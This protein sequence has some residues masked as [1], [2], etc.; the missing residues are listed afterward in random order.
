MTLGEPFEYTFLEDDFDALHQGDQ[1]VGQLFFG[2]SILA[3]LIA[4]L[5][6][7]GL[8]SYATEQRTKEIG[9]RKTLG[10]SVTDIVLLMS[11]NFM[12]LV[13]LALVIAI[14]ITWAAMNEWLQLFA[15]RT[16]IDAGVFLMS[17]LMA[18]VIAFG[19]VSFQSAKAALTNPSLI[20]RDE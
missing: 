16:E 4:C 11:R 17:G 9:V 1:K 5:G 8:A 13:L 2:F 3:I 15:Y 20:L 18:L 10:A 7:Y 6:L 19:T 14:P 12:L